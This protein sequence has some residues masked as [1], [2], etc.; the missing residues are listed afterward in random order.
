[1]RIEGF[2]KV[3]KSGWSNQDNRTLGA[4]RVLSL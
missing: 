4:I 3:G 2:R 1:L